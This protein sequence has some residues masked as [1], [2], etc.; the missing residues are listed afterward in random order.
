MQI[1]NIGENGYV[2]HVSRTFYFASNIS[3]ENIFRSFAVST[4]TTKRTFSVGTYF[5]GRSGEEKQ[6]YRPHQNLNIISLNRCNFWLIPII[7]VYQHTTGVALG[8]H[9]IKI[10]GWG[11]EAGTPYWLVVNSWNSDWGDAG[12]ISSLGRDHIH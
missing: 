4:T 12:R 2:F 7:G 5:Q 11:T 3:N 8:D 1:T 10:I 9:A 6:S